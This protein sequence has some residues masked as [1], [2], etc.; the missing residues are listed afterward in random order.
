MGKNRWLI[1][2]LF[3]VSP[4]LPAEEPSFVLFENGNLERVKD[5][6]EE[7]ESIEASNLRGMTPLML[8]A[9]HNERV[10]VLNFLIESG[11]DIAAEDNFGEAAIIKAA[12][13]NGNPAILNAL[14]EAGAEFDASYGYLGRTP[15]MMA[16]GLNANP[17][18]PAL[19]LDNGASFDEED[20]TVQRWT[21][22]FYA[23]SWNDNPEVVATLIE[24]GANP[25]RRS[26][27][28]SRTPLMEAIVNHAPPAVVQT[29]IDAG[30]D[31]MASGPQGV[32]ILMEAAAFATNPEVLRI[33]VRGGA[34]VDQTV[35][36]TGMTP[37][38]IACLRSGDPRIVEA[39][40]D[41][42]AQ[43]ELKNNYG[44][45]ALDYLEENPRLRESEAR[46]LLG[47][48]VSN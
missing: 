6:V 44:A 14:I 33:L 8:A 25:N 24:S 31:A 28:I 2:V 21:P 40:L 1:S 12:G 35:P 23:A 30:A 20:N 19:L 18:V 7:L 39:L 37:L 15:L 42:G 36:S 38:M 5:A 32:T 4:L 41:L 48:R 3:A 27:R 47:G 26:S 17:E 45:T 22:I 29:L 13:Y 9:K 34:L 16:A 11:A 10:E 43:P 46:E